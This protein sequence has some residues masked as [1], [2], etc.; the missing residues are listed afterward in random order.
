MV[1]RVDRRV[2]VVTVLRVHVLADRRLAPLPECCC[3]RDLLLLS[4]V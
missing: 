4:V 1:E 3:V 2:E